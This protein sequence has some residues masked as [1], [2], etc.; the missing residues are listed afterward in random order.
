MS[1]H[2]GAD[3]N[4]VCKFQLV[5][6]PWKGAKGNVVDPTLERVYNDNALHILAPHRKSAGR[7]RGNH[8]SHGRH[9]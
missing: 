1:Q 4:C 8:V 9:L 6:P 7:G 2:G 5:A 3:D